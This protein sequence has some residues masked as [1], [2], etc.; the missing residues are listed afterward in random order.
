MDEALSLSET[1]LK[2]LRAIQQDA[3]G[4]ARELAERLGMS[5]STLWRRVNELEQVGAIKSRVAI[6]DPERAGFSVCVFVFVNLADYDKPTLQRFEEFVNDTP[7]ILECFAVTGTNDYPADGPHPGARIGRV[8]DF[9]VCTAPTQILDCPT[10]VNP[11]SDQ[12]KPI[13]DT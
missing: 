2:V 10:P 9:A 8:G 6:V 1:D 11:G 3:T 12:T 13:K 7:E 5:P 4:S